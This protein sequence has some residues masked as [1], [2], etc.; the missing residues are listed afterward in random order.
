MSRFGRVLSAGSLLPA[1]VLLTTP[2]ACQ[3]FLSIDEKGP[4]VMPDASGSPD[5]R[6]DRDGEVPASVTDGGSADAALADG[7]CPFI[8]CDDFELGGLG[9]AGGLPPRNAWSYRDAVL[10]GVTLSRS[11]PG[12]GS[13]FSLLAQA[14]PGAQMGAGDYLVLRLGTATHADVTFDLLQEGLP[15]TVIEA[16]AIAHTD[17]TQN[18]VAAAFAS[19]HVT[20][21][22]ALNGLIGTPAPSSFTPP[23][24]WAKFKLVA[25]VKLG[26]LEVTVR[27]D[28]TEVKVDT[29]SIPTGAPLFVRLGMRTNQAAEGGLLRFD[30]VTI[31]A[32]SK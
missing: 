23:P 13:N 16:V 27:V 22:S 30:N 21:L 11:T 26:N 24:G 12:N 25:D 7:G 28:G 5:P 3:A 4:G 20:T 31:D 18:Y 9:P 19:G 10:S 8:L 32:N 6:A 15:P 17:V 14:R 29:V 2:L 1:C